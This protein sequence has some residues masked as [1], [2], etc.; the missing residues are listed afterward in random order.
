M[1]SRLSERDVVRFLALALRGLVLLLKSHNHTNTSFMLAETQLN[2]LGA[3]WQ[4]LNGVITIRAATPKTT[5]GYVGLT[6]ALNKNVPSA[7]LVHGCVRYFTV[8]DF[9]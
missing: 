2:C 3:M 5:S 9:H 8:Q 1:I 6:V 4:S 7:L